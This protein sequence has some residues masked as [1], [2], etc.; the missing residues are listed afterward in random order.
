[1]KSIVLFDIFSQAFSKVFEKKFIFLLHV[2]IL[3]FPDIIF[4]HIIGKELVHGEGL[5]NFSAEETE[6]RAIGRILVRPEQELVEGLEDVA[7]LEQLV[8]HEHAEQRQALLHVLDVV[9]PEELEELLEEHL[10]L[11]GLPEP[12]HVLDEELAGVLHFPVLRLRHALVQQFEVA[13]E[14]LLDFVFGTVD[15]LFFFFRL[16]VLLALGLLVAGLLLGLVAV[17]VALEDVLE[18][19][20]A[21]LGVLALGPVLVSALEDVLDQAGEALVDVEER[22][23]LFQKFKYSVEFEM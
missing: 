11:A 17:L 22:L 9:A 8:F 19:H 21:L 4:N 23:D 2:L 10:G 20:G 7:L 15:P 12:V 5:E 16:D 3:D 6:L 14:A 13:L 1:M 18:D